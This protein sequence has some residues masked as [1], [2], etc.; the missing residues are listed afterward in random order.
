MLIRGRSS[1]CIRSRSTFKCNHS[2]LILEK[3]KRL[4]LLFLKGL[5]NFIEMKPKEYYRH[6]S[7]N[8]QNLIENDCLSPTHT[9]K[10]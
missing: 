1:D 7:K 8:L 4:R 2:E 10:G 3:V 5:L 9:K 6:Y